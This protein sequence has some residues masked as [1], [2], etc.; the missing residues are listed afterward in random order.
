M[1]IYEGSYRWRWLGV[2]GSRYKWKLTKLLVWEE[3]LTDF[4]EMQ[5]GKVDLACAHNFSGSLLV[6]RKRR[7]KLFSTIVMLMQ[8]KDT[9]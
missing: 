2:A 5:S 3:K 6:M 7:M 1:Q 9:L 8:Y 4:I